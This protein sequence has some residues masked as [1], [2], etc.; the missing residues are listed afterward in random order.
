[1][2][3]ERFTIKD[4]PVEDRPRERLIKYGSEALSN[5]ELLAIIL[6]TGTKSE[7]AIDMATRLISSNEGLKFLSSCTIQELSQVKGIG[8]AKASQIKAAVELGKR[9][10]N[11]RIDN[12]IKINS[13]EDIADLVMEDMRYLKKEHLRV[14]FLNTKNIVIDVK[15]LS[16]GSLN[17]SVVHPREIY[18]EAIRRSSA[19]IIICHNHPSGDP[20][21]SQ[22]DINITRRLYEVG[23]LVGIDLLDHVIIGDGCYISLKEKGIL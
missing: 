14:I 12:K 10:K 7:T 8:Q 11:Y 5:S 6:R 4:I 3:S 13:P 18:S 17:A 15:D 22:E 20:T 1:M 19:A 21:S 2:Q 23:K 16:V 9:L